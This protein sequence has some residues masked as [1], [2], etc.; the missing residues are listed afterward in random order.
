M[1]F[2]SRHMRGLDDKGFDFLHE[3][4][5]FIGVNLQCDW[6]G[7]IQTED[8]QNR[9]SI[10]DMTAHTQIHVVGMPVDDVHEALYVFGQT[11]LDIDSSHDITPYNLIRIGADAL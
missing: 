9:L 1:N 7:K 4:V 5:A 8:A 3:I 11:K 6:L 2:R 10:D